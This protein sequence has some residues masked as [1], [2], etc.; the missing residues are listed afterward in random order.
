M[1]VVVTGAS[2][3]VGRA[4]VAVLVQA[5]HDV[6]AIAR[7]AALNGNVHGLALD[8]TQDDLRP[9]LRDADAVIHLVGIIRERPEA[10][11]TFERLH[12]DATRRVLDAVR[13]TNVSRL[14]HMSALGTS[15]AGGS[16]YFE[17]KWAAEEAVRQAWPTATIVR[18]SL[19]FGGGADFFATLRGL[20]R[21]PVVPVPGAGDTPFDPVARTDVAQALAA[22]IADSTAEGETYEI[23]GPERITLNQLIDRVGAT[24][25][26]SIPLPKMHIPVGAL[27]PLVSLGERLP[28]FPL[29]R[30]QLAMLRIPNVTDDI[31]WH[32]WVPKPARMDKE[33]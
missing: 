29:T 4:A 1:R 32:K 16:A 3:Y 5:G 25:G 7:H 33:L 18:P 15:K 26:R 28:R 9:A 17:T 22:M 10:G 30:D 20:A 31:R 13:Q 19:M 12:V 11:V 8:V 21:N 23:G 6:V 2:G 24:L 27:R 14:V